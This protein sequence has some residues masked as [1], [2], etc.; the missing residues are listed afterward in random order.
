MSEERKVDGDIEATHDMRL[1][2]ANKVKK[3]IL[4]RILA[5]KLIDYRSELD[6]TRKVQIVT[7]EFSTE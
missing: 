6:A 1:R 2:A 5:G 3:M 7:I 4:E